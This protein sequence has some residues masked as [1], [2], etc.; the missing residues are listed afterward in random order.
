MPKVGDLTLMYVYIFFFRFICQMLKNEASSYFF[1]RLGRIPFENDLITNEVLF[2]LPEYHSI[3][4]VFFSFD[5]R[6]RF[7][8]LS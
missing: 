7:Y 5:L 4:L 2:L 3:I 1:K 6:S 8:L